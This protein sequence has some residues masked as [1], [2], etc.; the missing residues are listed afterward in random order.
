MQLKKHSNE[1]RIGH[2]D[3]VCENC[4]FWNLDEIKCQRYPPT[5]IENIKYPDE[6]DDPYSSDFP[7]SAPDDWC[8][9]FKK[10]EIWESRINIGAQCQKRIT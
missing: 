8:G 2:D 1:R 6:D 3:A 4:K 7:V 10:R 9:E 5:I